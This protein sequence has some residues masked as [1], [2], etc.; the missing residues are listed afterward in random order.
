MNAKLEDFL[1]TFF[2][3][4][5]V[6]GRKVRIPYW[7]NKFFKDRGRIQ[8]P[9]GGK[10]AP[11]QIKQATL[12]K[13]KESKIDLSQPSSEQIRDFMR[14]K[15]IGLD[16]SGFAFQVLN[17]L[18]PGFH[19]NLKKAEGISLNPI[20]RFS[21]RALTSNRNSQPVKK[22]KNIKVGD[23]I[24][25]SFNDQNIDHVL[26]VVRAGKKEIAY[27]HSSRKTKITGPHL[28]K[29][30]VID[31]NLGLEKQQWL[32]KTKGGLSLLEFAC[33]PLKKGGV[34]RCLGKN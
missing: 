8:G 16:C 30:K 17:F 22:T 6:P 28:G 1:E 14:Q 18:K 24:P 4:E 10:G 31:P 25:V 12:K 20:R 34:R 27:A 13:A 2:A 21:V 23:L 9:L 32:E 29:I 15:R 26:V 11:A 19:K 5:I 7:R 33:Q 3:L